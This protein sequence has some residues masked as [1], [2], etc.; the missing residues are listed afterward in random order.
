M[1]KNGDYDFLKLPLVK[2][3]KSGR[4]AQRGV[5]DSFKNRIQR[6]TDKSYYRDKVSEFMTEE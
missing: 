6:L 5:F 3:S 1:A 4:A 2:A